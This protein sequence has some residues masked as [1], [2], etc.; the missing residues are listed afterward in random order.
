[1]IYAMRS[2]SLDKYA[3]NM[4]IQ[5][6]A[7]FPLLH[8][9]GLAINHWSCLCHDNRDRF[10]YNGLTIDNMDNQLYQL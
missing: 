10:Y 4:A 9:V 2:L 3:S 8:N 5:A 6:L 7:R 1:M